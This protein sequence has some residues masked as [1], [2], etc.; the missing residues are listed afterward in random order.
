MSR[1]IPRDCG[2]RESYVRG[3]RSRSVNLG[4]GACKHRGGNGI[5]SAVLERSRP[6]GVERDELTGKF[7]GCVEWAFGER[8]D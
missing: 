1:F 7:K 8:L 3:V 2:C 4:W 5:L 6:A